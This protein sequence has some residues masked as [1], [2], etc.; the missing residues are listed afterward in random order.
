MIWR[1]TKCKRAAEAPERL[2]AK[3]VRRFCWGCSRR[4][5]QLV[6]RVRD[7]AATDARE[8]RRLYA[9]RK[10]V[11]RE[12]AR[13]ERAAAKRKRDK[14][15]AAKAA[16]KKLRDDADQRIAAGIPWHVRVWH[17]N[18][19]RVGRVVGRCRGEPLRLKVKIGSRLAKVEQWTELA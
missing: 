19:Y 5:G 2:G 1:C 13:K 14:A 15:R 3:D 11:E 16:A 6:E 12:A 9:E 17:K 18:G 8:Q 7:K 10:T 4:T